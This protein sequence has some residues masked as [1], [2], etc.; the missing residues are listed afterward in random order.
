MSV[1]RFLASVVLFLA[2]C[3]CRMGRHAGYKASRQVRRHYR[4]VAVCA[5]CQVP[6]R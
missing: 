5:L 4:A 6:I 3:R 2:R 1:D